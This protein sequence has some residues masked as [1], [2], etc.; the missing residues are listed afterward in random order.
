MNFT[1]ISTS[2]GREAELEWFFRSVA[3]QTFAGKTEVIFVNQ[4]SDRPACSDT[5]T[6]PVRLIELRT[7]G[8]IPLSKARNLALRCDLGDIVA[9]PDDDCWYEPQLLEKIAAYFLNNPG[10]DCICT[11]VYDPDRNLPY[12]KRPVG[13][14]RTITFANVFMLSISV[15]IFVRKEALLRAGAF[16]DEEL[17]AG[18]PMGSGEETE[19]LARLLSAGCRIEYRGDLQVYHPVSVYSPADIQ[20]NYRY[21][22]GFGYLNGRLLL[23]GHPGV[24]WS[25]TGIVARSLAGAVVNLGNPVRR[26]VYWGRLTGII[27]GF[28]DVLVHTLRH[29]N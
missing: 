14:T 5:L 24:L 19:L 10:V 16:F 11:N 26:A 20:K 22:L 15:G 27:S 23:A 21:G 7:G 18:T 17:G 8:R 2:C 6:A 28:I 29:D 1:L 12:G 9:F 4:D 25:F 13:V 3:K